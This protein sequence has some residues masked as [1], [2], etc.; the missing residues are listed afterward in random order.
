M[1]A[2]KPIET[3]KLVHEDKPA[4]GKPSHDETSEAHTDTE[5]IQGYLQQ[6][7]IFRLVVFG[8]V[9][10]AIMWYTKR[11]RNQYYDE[12]KQDEKYNA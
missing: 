3:S 10:S 4:H 1:D 7:W 12:L 8:A 11:R 6:E 9:F 5:G 2:T